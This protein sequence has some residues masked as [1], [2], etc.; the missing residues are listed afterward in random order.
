MNLQTEILRNDFEQSFLNAEK[1]RAKIYRDYNGHALAVPYFE[2]I[3][4]DK[5]F[6]LKT[7][8]A[9]DIAF[10]KAYKDTIGD[11]RRCR[12]LSENEDYRK[13]IKEALYWQLQ[14][15]DELDDYKHLDV[16][17][18]DG[19]ELEAYLMRKI[20]RK[21]L[22]DFKKQRRMNRKARMYKWNYFVTITYDSKK[23]A[24]EQSFIDYLRKFLSNMSSRHKWCY[25]GVFERGER[26]ERLHFH[27]LMYIP[28]GHMIGRLEMTEKCYDYKTGKQKQ[29]LQNSYLLDMCGRNEFDPVP[30]R[31]NHLKDV[32]SY[33]KKYLKK[34]GEK[35]RYS[36]GC[37]EEIQIIITNEDICAQMDNSNSG[38]QFVLFDNIIFTLNKLRRFLQ[39][40]GEFAD[41]YGIAS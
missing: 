37:P 32:V 16:D 10:D 34:S 1:I 19:N 13:K 31:G 23:F 17:D 3:K 4:E 7:P 28:E 21:S 41:L 14:E 6:V 29:G 18:E 9:L 12:R 11:Y 33:I 40:K 35:I 22:N 39:I 5:E 8:T 36:R 25:M 38:P 15:S 2:A 24:D 27:A 26:N 30:E 20:D